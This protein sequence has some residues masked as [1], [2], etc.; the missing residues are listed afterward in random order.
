MNLKF[1]GKRISGILAILPEYEAHFDD[2]IQNYSLSSSNSMKLKKIMGY[3]K[4]RIVSD[5]VC[6]SDLCTFGLKHLF[7]MNLLDKDEIDALILVTQTPDYIVPPTSNIIQGTLGL[8]QDLL[9]LDINQGCAGYLV[10]LIEAFLLLGNNAFN[11]IVL[12]NADVLSRKVSKQDRNSYPLIGDAASI[13]IIERDAVESEVF[14]TLK[15]DGSRAEALIIPAGGMRL[16]ATD[17]TAALELDGDNLRSKNHLKMDGGAVFNFMQTEVP[18]MINDLM[19]FAGISKDDIDYFLFHQPNKFM[20]QKL[21]NKIGISPVKMPSNIVENFGN[22]SGVSVPV[23]IAFNL[24]LKLTEQSYAICL[25]G[26]GSGLAW[27][28]MFLRI[29]EL[30]FCGIMEFGNKGDL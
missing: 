23:N 2:E 25:A 6:V 17:S 7:E 5:E 24:G 21:T 11:K 27:S 29:G 30:N 8:K 4:H 9:C 22:S 18:P 14:A 26:F 19:N 15:M 3:D 10:G 13:T 12:L 20:L 1:Q 28:S 16:P